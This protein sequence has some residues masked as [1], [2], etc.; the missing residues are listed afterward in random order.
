MLGLAKLLDTDPLPRGLEQIG[1]DQHRRG[2][3]LAAAGDSKQGGGLHLDGDRPVRAP[4]AL[5][6]G[7]RVIEEVGGD[8]ETG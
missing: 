2:R 3:G 4:A 7:P 1:H 8:D 6:T 5:D